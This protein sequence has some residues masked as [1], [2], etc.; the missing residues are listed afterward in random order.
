MSGPIGWRETGPGEPVD[1][2]IFVATEFPGSGVTDGWVLKTK[3][4]SS[5]RPANA[6]NC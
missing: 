3:P 6:V 2:R 1:W 4:R 5:G